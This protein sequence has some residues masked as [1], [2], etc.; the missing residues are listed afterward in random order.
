MGKTFVSQV[1]GMVAELYLLNNG[2]TRAI[3]YFSEHI[4]VP[5]RTVIQITIEE[6]TENV[7]QSFQ[8]CTHHDPPLIIWRSIS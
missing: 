7:D 5:E 4:H 8:N 1:V 3:I 2:Q 6:L